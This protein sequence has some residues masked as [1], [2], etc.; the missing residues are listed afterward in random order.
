MKHRRKRSTKSIRGSETSSFLGIPVGRRAML[1]GVFGLVGAA[2]IGVLATMRQATTASD[3][4]ELVVYRDPGCGCCKK[5]VAHLQDHFTVK[6]T[7]SQRLDEV[8][9]KLGVPDDLIGCHTATV[10]GLTI[11]GHVPIA[12][13]QRLLRERP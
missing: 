11:E 13:I 4:P 1:L 3:K 7:P 6:D 9:R 12:E 2:G 10:A 5:W 8:R